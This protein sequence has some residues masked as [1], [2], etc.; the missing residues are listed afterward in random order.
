MKVSR[1]PRGGESM[2]RAGH[3]ENVKQGATARGHSARLVQIT[4][5]NVWDMPRGQREI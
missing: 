4:D 5:M 2:L 3:V 1:H